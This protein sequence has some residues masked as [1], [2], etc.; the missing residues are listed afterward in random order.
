[1]KKILL[2]SFILLFL[3]LDVAAVSGKNII[4]S[5]TT[6]KYLGLN[7]DISNEIT[8]W[9]YNIA[10]TNSNKGIAV[11]YYGLILRTTDGGLN[12]NKQ[13]S[14]VTNYLNG[15]CFIDSCN[16]M[17]VGQYGIILKSTDAGITWIPQA[18]GISNGDLL[19][20]SFADENIGIAVGTNDFKGLIEVTTD[21]GKSWTLQTISDAT[22]MKC[23]CFD[24]YNVIAISSNGDI[25]KSTDAG[26]TWSV[27]S[28]QKNKFYNLND[29]CFVD[30]NNGMAVGFNGLILKTTDGGITWNRL[31]SGTATHLNGVSFI[32]E[33]N[34][35]V[36][37]NELIISTT[38]G[39][40]DWYPQSSRTIYPLGKVCFTDNNTGTAVGVNA[41]I[42]R[43]TDGGINWFPQNGSAPFLQYPLNDTFDSQV[44]LEFSWE[45]IVT[46]DSAEFQLSD[47]ST[48]SYSYIDT[49][50]TSTNLFI[51]NLRDSTLFY[52]RV[53]GIYPNGYV[54]WSK[55][56]SF[57]TMGKTPLPLNPKNDSTV[58]PKNICFQWKEAASVINYKL[59]IS[60]DSLFLSDVIEVDT[61]KSLSF[62]T[63]LSYS[64]KYF[65]RVGA[66]NINGQT[67]WSERWTF[68]SRRTPKTTFPLDVGNKW[69]Y[70]AI[71]WN[72]LWN[73]TFSKYGIIKE[74]IDTL[75]N[76]FRKVSSKYYYVDSTITKFEYWGYI[77]GK[78][79]VTDTPSLD[80]N[81]LYFDDYLETTDTCTIDHNYGENECRNFL[82]LQ[83]FGELATGQSY[84]FYN[85]LI[86][87]WYKDY[88]ILL[89]N[90]GIAKTI[91]SE[92]SKYTYN[93]C[94][95]TELI[96]MVKNDKVLG[97]TVFNI[98]VGVDG[99]KN[100]NLP[101][102]YALSQNYPNPFNPITKISYQLPFNSKVNLK[103]FDILGR[104]VTTLVN[105][106]KPAGSYEVE[107]NGSNLPSGIYFYK[108]Q[109]GN[110]SSI[111][112]MISLK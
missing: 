81:N 19:S 24:R 77:D 49:L 54:E 22:L 32:D 71:K 84:E 5:F 106:E 99:K 88:E 50:I 80:P 93:W 91:K 9:L 97:D 44:N 18:S 12:W 39:G 108:L 101:L 94:D 56:R 45:Y 48:F 17:A 42:L 61:L 64:T 92:Y 87:Y 57:T 112:K 20:V 6:S 40:I 63:N 89:E 104:E 78:F 98:L 35:T 2:L 65:W 76:G 3:F 100:S 16:V 36:V 37:G 70:Q 28:K 46:P 83:I 11:G 79:Y 15:V 59:Q 66:R 73:H 109:A 43:T 27:W 13:N 31:S 21:G 33:N 26:L 74:I 41:M 7:S 111:R 102:N 14:G 68:Y 51:N 72:L 82:T 96:G 30:I 62:A 95:S 52:W 23:V 90:I 105:E 75:S 38:N 1:M 69:Y 110:Y 25:F 4:K 8:A 29:V 58:S 10:F 34:C 85:F 86:E 103:I 67:Y 60:S 53:R 47:D 107:F 55:I